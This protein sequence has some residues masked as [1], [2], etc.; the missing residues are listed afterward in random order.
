M[1]FITSKSYLLETLQPLAINMVAANCASGLSL[2]STKYLASSAVNTSQVRD[3][4][5][6]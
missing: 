3:S 1:A 4:V 6:T 5:I 2:C